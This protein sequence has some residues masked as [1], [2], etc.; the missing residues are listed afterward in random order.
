MREGVELRRHHS[1]VLVY[2]AQNMSAGVDLPLRLNSRV[3]LV[4]K[5]CKNRHP[6]SFILNI[7]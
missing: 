4:L 3:F 7:M 2:A 5:P 1:E 6:K